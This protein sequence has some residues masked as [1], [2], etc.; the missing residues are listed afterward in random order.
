[1]VLLKPQPKHRCILCGKIVTEADSVILGGEYYCLDHPQVLKD[2][3]RR[4]KKLRKPCPV[5]P[6]RGKE[7]GRRT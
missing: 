3:E 4:L 7:N 2:W 5:I 6:K 1:M